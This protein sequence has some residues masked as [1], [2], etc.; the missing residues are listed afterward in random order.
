M[1][2]LHPRLTFLTL[3]HFCII[4]VTDGGVGVFGVVVAVIMVSVGLL[5]LWLGWYVVCVIQ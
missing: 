1:T 5:C 3:L 2:S 4:E